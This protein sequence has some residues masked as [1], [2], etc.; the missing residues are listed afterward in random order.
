MEEVDLTQ[1]ELDI[2]F[3]DLLIRKFEPN[4]N[5]NEIQLCESILTKILET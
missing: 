3:N 2:V 5:E 1:S 4:T